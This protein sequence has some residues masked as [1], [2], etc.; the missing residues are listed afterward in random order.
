M[1]RLLFIVPYP[2]LETVVRHVLANHPEKGRL[3]ADIKVMT[4]EQTPDLPEHE[5]D[6]I[7]ARGLSAQKTSEKY[8]QIPTIAL[9]ISGYDTVRAISECCNAYSPKKIAFVSSNAQ[10]YEVRD[11]CRFFHTDAEIYAPVSHKD[12]EQTVSK[13]LAAGCDAL[14]G[15]YSANLAAGR[16]GLPSVV[17][18]TGAA[19]VLQTT[20]EA[21]HTADRIRQQRIRSQMY[22]TIIYSSKDGILYVNTQGIIQVRNAVARKLNGDISLQNRPLKEA[23]PYLY[24]IFLTVLREGKEKMGQILKIPGSKTQVSV[25]FTPVVA[26]HEISGVVINL[27]DITVIQEME[28]QIRR[29]LSERGHRA[30]YTFNDIIHQSAA[31]DWTIEKAKRYAASNSNVI[32]IGETGV[33]KELFSQSIHN[34]SRRK[35]GPFVAINCAALPESLLE[36]ELFGYVEGAFTGTSKGGKMGLFEQAHGGTLFLDEVNELSLST[37]SKL[38]R[39]LQEQQVRRIG[40]NRVIDINVRILA[41]ANKN[42]F[43]LSEQGDF[44]KDLLYRLD[45]LRLFLPPLREREN[46]TELL[47]CHFLKLYSQEAGIAVPG[48]DAD[49]VPLL[50]QYPFGG[51][52]RELRN[53]AERVAVLKQ[54]DTIRKEDLQEALYPEDLEVANALSGGYRP[55]DQR[56]ASEQERLYQALKQTGGNQTKAA[57][58]LGI[59]R[60]TLWRKLRKY[61]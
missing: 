27:S 26:N 28:S 54:G 4:V 58:L 52:I 9:S 1:I 46:D 18:K 30:R 37:Q 10:M 20:D 48:I 41:A 15:G 43:Q 32:I 2:E 45:V 31:I 35:N 56:Y 50:Y 59:D 16:Y 60:S 3:N 29:K 47:F 19:A 12:L 39:V 21:I 55:P 49:A 57:K 36:S 5:Y 24:P 53:I 22:K 8:P 13:A 33:G 17:I 6:A 61:Q 14:I 51:N 11:I 25:N 42:I 23:L 44:R 34:S 40:D 38:L 7:I